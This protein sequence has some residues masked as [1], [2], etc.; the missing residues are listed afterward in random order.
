MSRR[1]LTRIDLYVAAWGVVITLASLVLFDLQTMLSVLAG[2]AL[3]SANW[4]AF[5]W[6]GIRMAA[7]G[8]KSRFGIFLA[9][10]GVAILAVVAL[11]LTTNDVIAPLPFTVGLSSLVLGVMTRGAHQAIIEGNAALREDG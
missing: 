11:I 5:R 2:A 10:K 4:L 7:T 3:S 1:V 8:N 9:V 6:F